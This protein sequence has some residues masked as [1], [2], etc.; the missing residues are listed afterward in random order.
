MP[1]QDE[2]TPS[3]PA[4]S[5]AA[6][7]ERHARSEIMR[8]AGK[9]S[10]VRSELWTLHVS[11]QESPDEEEI[12]EGEKPETLSFAYRAA[13]ESVNEDRL[14]PAIRYL[15]RTALHTVRSLHAEWRNR[16]NDPLRS[17]EK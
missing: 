8:A 5:M 6:Y 2:F 14:D 10:A 1:S 12:A 16:K 4:D 15:E 9:L 7:E 17:G 11:L 13:I 3:N